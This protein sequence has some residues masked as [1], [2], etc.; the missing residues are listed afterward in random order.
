[1]HRLGIEPWTF[2]SRILRFN[3]S[4]TKPLNLN[5]VSERP[6]RQQFLQQIW[7]NAHE[8]RESL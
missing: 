4:A 7:A 3:R 1:M 6:K 5:D 2:R 8:T